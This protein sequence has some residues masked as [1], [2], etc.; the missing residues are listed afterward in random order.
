MGA[1]GALLLLLLLLLPRGSRQ[2]LQ[3]GAGKRGVCERNMMITKGG[4]HKER[5]GA[6]RQRA[7]RKTRAR[8][9]R[10]VVF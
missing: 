3:G 9:R 4:G 5:L 6:A 1:G 7:G 8:R 2:I 10:V